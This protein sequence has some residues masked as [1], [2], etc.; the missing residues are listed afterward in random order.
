VILDNSQAFAKANPN[1]L[2][3]IVAKARAAQTQDRVRRTL[4]QS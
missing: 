3:T 2:N 4:G 1:L